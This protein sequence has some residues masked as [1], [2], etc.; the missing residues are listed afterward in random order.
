[1]KIAKNFFYL[2]FIII[3]FS[4][5]TLKYLKNLFQTLEYNCYIILMSLKPDSKTKH[6]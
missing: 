3:E 5:K 4:N 1:M 2:D 6:H